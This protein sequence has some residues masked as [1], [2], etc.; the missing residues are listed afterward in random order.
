MKIITETSALENFCH[1]AQLN[2]FITI[3]TEF[4]RETT[5]WPE[6]CLIQ[7]AL[8]D[9]AVLIDPLSRELDLYP[10]FELLRNDKVIKVFHSARQDIEI[11]YHLTGEIPCNIFDTQIAAMVCGFGISV[12]YEVLVQ[13]Y[14]RT[15]IDK[16]SRYTNWANR[17][18]TKKQMEYAQADVTHLRVIYD[19]LY[20]K[21]TSEDRYHWLEDEL[22][23]LNDPNTYAIDPYSV[24]QKIRIRSPKPRLLGVLRELAAWREIRAQQKNVPRGRIMRDDVL[25]ELSAAA[26]ATIE[27]LRRMRGLNSSIIHDESTEILELVK[28]AQSLPIEDCPQIKPVKEQ[29]PGVNAL[30]EML[31]LLLK[32]KADRYQVAAKLIATSEDIEEIA[33]SNDPQV[34]ALKG[35]RNEVFGV[36]AMKLKKGEVAIGVKNDKISLIE[37]NGD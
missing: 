36:D 2:S 14:A 35:W 26:P 13:K 8:T 32:I 31:K 11:F 10:L 30:I 3:D 19:K 28:K 15:S 25:V 34:P 29:I 18:L 4:I 20:N 21:I 17:P 22:K 6:L 5:Y 24:W 12:G 27:D 7:I 23:I 1:K 37:L 33:R 9:E 16:S